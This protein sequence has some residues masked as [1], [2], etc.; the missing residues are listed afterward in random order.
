MT[1]ETLKKNL[2]KLSWDVDYWNVRL[3]SRK[4]EYLSVRQGVVTPPFYTR[5]LGAMVTVY[6]NGGQGY[7]ATPD[8]SPEGLQKAFEE[9]LR[10]AKLSGQHSVTKFDSDLLPVETGNLR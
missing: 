6:D 4:D 8:L 5:D 10:W 2:K 7:G 9:A 1:P 3:V